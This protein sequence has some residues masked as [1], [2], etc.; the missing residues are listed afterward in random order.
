VATLSRISG[1]R[2]FGCKGLSVAKTTDCE[3]VHPN[4]CL[5]LC[6]GI[7]GNARDAGLAVNAW[8][9]DSRV[10]GWALTQRGV[11]GLI[12]SSPHVA[13]WVERATPASVSSQIEMEPLSDF[14]SSPTYVIVDKTV[15]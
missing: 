10:G 15:G 4:T 6:T 7:V 8:T 12:A 9:V 11:D 3:Y 14:G 1:E 5:C 13:S 2:R